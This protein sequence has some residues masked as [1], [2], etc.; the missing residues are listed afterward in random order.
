MEGRVTYAPRYA[1]MT[2]LKVRRSIE[3][4]R[5]GLS[6][7]FYDEGLRLVLLF[8]STVSGKIHNKSDIDIAF[9]FGKPVDIL[10]AYEQGRP[11]TRLM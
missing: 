2:H 9:F 11:A 4:I 10:A 5:E 3:E 6:P 1:S 8:G 7:L